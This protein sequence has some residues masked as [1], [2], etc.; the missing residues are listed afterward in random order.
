MADSTVQATISGGQVQGVAGA[1]VV[2]VK[3]FTIINRAVEQPAPA[4]AD[5][6][7][8]PLCPYP[9]LAHFGPGEAG[10]FFGRDAAIKRLGAAVSQ[11]SL[12]A[13]VGASGTGKSSVVLAGL[14]PH[15]ART[16]DWLFSYFRI[17]TEVDHNPFRALAR[18]LVP[19]YVT[20]DD[21]TERLANTKKLACKLQDGE[22]TLRDVFADC[23]N[24]SKNRRILLIADQ[25]EE[26]FTLLGDEALQQRFVDVLLAGFPDPA[27]GMAP[28]IGLILTLRADF[29]GRALRHRPLA[30]AL[31]G[32]LENLGPMTRDELRDAIVRPAKKEEVSFEPGLVHTLL[33]DVGG[34]PGSLPLLQFALREMWERQENRTIARASYDAI[35][36][37]AGAL[38]Q[39][40]EKIFLTLTKDGAGASVENA[41]RRLFTRLVTLG[42]GQEDTRRVVE[43]R[44]LDEEA[45]KLAQILAGKNN[46]L[47]VT[48]APAP[49]RETVEVVHE[50]LIRHWPKLVDWI[51]KDRVFQAWL[52]QIHGG[53][54][55][56]MQDPSD[57]GPLLRGGMLVQAEDWLATR[58]DDL[59]PEER[60]F[61]EASVRDHGAREKREKF[62]R[63]LLFVSAVVALFLACAAT[64]AS[65][66]FYHANGETRE[67]A[68]EARKQAAEAQKQAAEAVA[69]RSR[70]LASL[71]RQQTAAGDGMSGMLVALE[72]L[73]LLGKPLP[74]QQAVARDVELA[75]YS[76]LMGNRELRILPPQIG[77]R[78]ASA[79][80]KPERV[81]AV[82]F[83][84][85]GRRVLVALADGSL[86]IWDSGTGALLRRLGGDKPMV[87]AVLEPNEG[88]LAATMTEEGEARLWNTNTGQELKVFPAKGEMPTTLGFSP[89]GRTLVAASDSGVV[90]LW[91]A[92][93]GQPVQTYQG[94]NSSPIRSVA[95]N[96]NASQVLIVPQNGNPRLLGIGSPAERRDIT[97]GSGGAVAANFSVDDGSV[98]VIWGD[99]TWTKD[100]AALPGS[101]PTSKLLGAS[102]RYARFSPSRH[103]FVTVTGD[104][105]TQVWNAG[106]GESIGKPIRESE[107][108]IV[109]AVFSSD[110]RSLLTLAAGGSLAASNFPYPV[111]LWNVLSGN[112]VATL[113]GHS[114]V[115]GFAEFSPDGTK[116]ATGSDDGTARIWNANPSQSIASLQTYRGPLGGTDAQG[117]MLPGFENRRAF[118]FTSDPGQLVVAS[119][120]R[121]LE[122]WGARSG[123]RS[124]R[125]PP[126]ETDIVRVAAH[127]QDSSQ[128]AGGALDGE[129]RIW[130]TKRSGQPLRLRQHRA[131]I[132][133]LNYVGNGRLLLAASLDGTASLWSDD[134]TLQAVLDGHA[135]PILAAALSPDG[136]YA[137]TGT[138]GHAAQLWSLPDGRLVRT[139][140]HPE[141]AVLALAFDGQGHLL[142]GSRAG[143]ARVWDV[144]EPALNQ[145]LPSKPILVVQHDGM[146]TTARFSPQTQRILTTCADGGAYLWDARTGARLLAITQGSGARILSALFLPS[147][148]ES[149]ELVLTTA[150]DG[151]V[152]I[153][154]GTSGDLVAT[155]NGHRRMAAGATLS[156]DGRLLATGSPAE[157][158]VRIWALPPQGRQE[159]VQEAMA[160]RTRMLSPED[161]ERFFLES[162]L[163]NR[164]EQA[165]P[166]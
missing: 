23:R 56:W 50:A 164:P 95:L 99:G 142:T 32:H 75:L 117:V 166:P 87:L 90:R 86:S 110:D 105:T 38:A 144:S 122:R 57:D 125:S 52:R 55:L 63:R 53:V 49:G 124:D 67:Q 47:V 88:V 42:E 62:Q 84:P 159:L 157:G 36:G 165:A 113:R 9:G 22:L 112:L 10:L 58:H 43:R 15:L 78:A 54:A 5:N 140:E 39:Q 25:F 109:S 30:D 98:I 96:R 128:V 4:P 92:A 66:A 21:D 150:E 71:S 100:A 152:E 103:S 154:N 162:H 19:L 121:R 146:V 69:Q 7:P 37:V 116:V 151:S 64:V 48:N 76:A 106:T 35:G 51:D 18:A 60:A 111:R 161:R 1:G 68:A 158:T 20:S 155:L 40:A 97:G 101:Q 91:E 148:D 34:K 77:S 16:G 79:E 132:S 24:R 130:D 127:P 33:D 115:A 153:H 11:R 2:H 123:T 160:R 83:S 12:T 118:A 72:A 31:Q 143:K 73:D 134:G 120:D 61:V 133:A 149:D 14:A 131:A 74:G 138:D 59:N 102:I 13:L 147:Q 94:D 129:V 145:A 17:G 29:Y 156:G 135:G 139:F 70:F 26:A 119:S 8:I 93:T 44:E 104:Q 89:D 107:G 108:E 6:G 28:D 82:R 126:F 46:R 80:A 137:A 3:N 136:R 141:G 81:T 65:V 85:D 41:F 45:W 114:L 163:G 27:Q